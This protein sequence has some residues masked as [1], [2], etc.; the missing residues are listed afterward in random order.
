[1]KW[2]IS[3]L[4]HIKKSVMPHGP[5]IYQTAYD[6]AMAKMSAYPSSQHALSHC[7]SSL[8]CCANFPHI[9][10]TRTESYKHHSTTFPTI[11]LCVY[12]L[13]SHF[14]VHGRH[15]LY[16]NKKFACVCVILILYHLEHYTQETSL[17]KWRHQFL[18][19]TQF[20]TFH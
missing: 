3:Y 8:N 10:L 6:M 12:Q 1:M 19:S 20:S 17:L 13:I 18:N 7:K 16:E 14:T 9:N 2:L 4:R 11:R 15:L 5:H